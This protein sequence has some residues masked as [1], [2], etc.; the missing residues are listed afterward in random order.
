MRRLFT[1]IAALCCLALAGRAAERDSL[2]VSLITCWPG[3]EIYELEGHEALRIRSSEGTDSVWNYGLFDFSEPNFVYRFVK[4]QTDYKLGA[5]P[6][7]W[8]MPSY[9]VQNRRVVEQELDLTQA[10]A[11]RLRAIL[12]HKALPQNA[13]YRY[14]Y[15][16]DNCATRLVA[17]LDSASGSPISYPDTV[18]YGTYREAMRSYHANY[19]W[20][21]FGIDVALGSGIDRRISARDEVFAP[22]RLAELARGARFADGRSLVKKERVLFL[23]G[24]AV[25]PPTPWWAG[26]LLWSWVLLALSIGVSLFDVRRGKMF[27]P[28]YSLW[29]LLTG[30]AGLLVTFLV[31]FSTH[32]ATSPNVLIM[33][34]NPMGLLMAALIW[35]RRLAMVATILSGLNALATG[36][37]LLVWAFQPQ[38]ANPAFFPLMAASVLLSITV[39]V[40]DRRL[41]AKKPAPARKYKTPRRKR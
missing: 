24:D 13:R 37:L 27:R 9:M 11:H 22:M 21:Q 26:P 14:K 8:F 28:W 38:S 30:M 25:L 1:L 41:P 20:Y 7:A 39:I 40:L 33:W 18:K 19:P 10:E 35:W 5:Y 3:P 31:V 4:G 2:T 6:F 16:T 32:E 36:I 15:L 34:L 17:N 23:G 12:R 29:F